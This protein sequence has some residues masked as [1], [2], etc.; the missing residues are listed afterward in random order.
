[1]NA[2]GPFRWSISALLL[3]VSA[4]LAAFAQTQQSPAKTDD[5][6]ASEV[7]LY[8]DAH[9][10]LD[11]PLSKL[12]RTVPELEGLKPAPDQE[13]LSDVLA[14]V[15]AKTDKLLTMVPDLISDEKV[16]QTQWIVV[17]GS[18]IPGCVRC[19]TPS[20]KE[21]AF[22]YIIFAHH[23][24]DGW[25]R[26][27]EYRADQKGQQVSPEEGPYFQGFVSAWTIFSPLNR[28]ESRFRLL[29]Q[30]KINGHSTYVIA[31]AQTPGSIKYPRQIVT[32]KVLLPLLLQGVAWVDQSDFRMVR[33]RT[34][35]LAP[36]S[37]IGL[38]QQTATIQFGMV[39]I[40]Q[41]ETLLWL[42]QGVN[43]DQES[44][45]EFFQEQHLYS[46]YRLYQVK[47]K[48]VAGPVP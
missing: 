47:S 14:K 25:L 31:F 21:R 15:G 44:K 1:M 20:R 16:T 27:E 35:I 11:S 28:E 10:Y 3:M 46:K 13:L 42:P 6:V 7:K 22:N 5:V 24:E 9:P 4:A 29:G 38:Q 2:S 37:E 26:P 41:L 45:D 36:L 23:A 48:I 34:D 18:A 12:R 8:A 32:D 43:V 40:A 30:Q 33:L 17:Q 19:G 39:R